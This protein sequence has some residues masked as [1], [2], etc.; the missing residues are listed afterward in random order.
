MS[1]VYPE[2]RHGSREGLSTE[3]LGIVDVELV[4]CE[5]L[6]WAQLGG[7]FDIKHTAV[8]FSPRAGV[9]LSRRYAA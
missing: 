1:V 2:I 6:H 3:Q 5:R 9:L 8:V 4:V 7:S